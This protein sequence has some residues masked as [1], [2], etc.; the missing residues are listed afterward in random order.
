MNSSEIRRLFLDYF[1]EKDHLVLPSF[2][3][4]PQSDPTLLLVGAGM[5]PLKAYFTGE[6]VPPHPRIATCQKCVRT[7]DI[8]RVGFTSRHA[9]FFEMLGNFSFGDYFKEGAIAM[10]WELMTEGYR[11]PEERLYVSIYQEDDEAFFIWRDQ[12]GVPEEKI[13]RL[14]KEDNFWEI[15]LGPCGPC[16]EIYY[17]RGPE[18]GCGGPGCE[19]GCDCDRYLELWNLVFTQFNKEADGSYTTLENKNIDT[20]AGLERLAMVLQDVPTFF[21]IDTV[22]PLLQHF[23]RKAGVT[24]G[25]DDEDDVS[26]RVITE[27]SRGVA[28]LVGDGIIPSNEGRGYV[29]RRIL[30]RAARFAK[31]LGIEP[32]SL[33]EAMPLVAEHMGDEYPELRDKLEHIMRVVKIEEERFKETLAQ[34][35]D[36]LEQKVA[37]LEKEGHTELSGEDAFKLYDTFGFPLDLTREILGEKGYAVDE[38]GFRQELEKQRERARAAQEEDEDESPVWQAAKGLS[39]EFVGYHTLESQAEVTAIVTPSGALQDEVDSQAE[40]GV[41]L[42]LNNTPFYPERGGQV[43][44]KG[45]IHGPR[46]KARVV[47]ALPGPDDAVL[48]Q[49]RVEEGT[50]ARGEQVEARVDEAQRSETARHHTATHLLHKALKEIVGEHVNQAGSLVSPSRLR[51]DLTHF[52]QLEE[53]ELRRLEE[54]VNELILAN[55]PLEAFYTTL[56]EAQQM[57]A[58]ALFDEK[59]G[60]K[61]RVV[62]I[63]DYSMELCGGTHVSAT[64]EIGIFKIVNESGIGSGMRR[65]EALTGAEAYRYFQQQEEMLRRAASLLRVSP[66][67]LPDK[68]R[69]LLDAQRQLQQ[70]LKKLQQMDTRQHIE[71]LLQQTDYSIGVPVLSATVEAESMEDLRSYLDRL[72]DK[73]QSGIILL[74]TVNNGKVLLAAAVTRDLV[75]KGFHAGRLISEVARMTGGGGGGRPD[76]AQAGGKDPRKLPEALSSVVSIVKEQQEQQGQ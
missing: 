67:R 9:T 44:D 3:L 56:E 7:P 30:R 12:I 46:G 28:F 27:H 72:R 58:V 52:S 54:R 15:G 5:A 37:S 22:A 71:D 51:F 4:V 8:E 63:D 64:G 42:V 40:E 10:A 48:H 39:T 34:G 49:V 25:E 43:G 1:R 14:G 19:V 74:G 21:E 70:K 61:V 53:E 29:L 16:S 31:L 17:D 33:Y 57:G 20:G 47:G 50:L 62:K 75:E 36:L 60:E 65:I 38:E 18:Y 13:Y 76:M 23:A 35:M 24:Y 6:K 66:E 68:L 11:F 69:E 59:Y 41:C 32:P 55:M 26:L 2:S 73:L 45:F